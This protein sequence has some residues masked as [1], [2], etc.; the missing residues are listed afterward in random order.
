MAEVNVRRSGLPNG[1]GNSTGGALPKV[2][3]VIDNLN[4]V[5]IKKTL[6]NIVGSVVIRPKAQMYEDL[7]KGI[8]GLTRLN[9]VNALNG[10]L[11][12]DFL[13]DALDDFPVDIV[14]SARNADGGRSLNDGS[15]IERRECE[16]YE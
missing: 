16:C 5:A 3:R 1:L 11:A 4:G 2:G 8:A 6:A 7:A 13:K 9:D 14:K 10:T 15:H 12:D